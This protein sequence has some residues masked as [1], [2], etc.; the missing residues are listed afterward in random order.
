MRRVIA[1]WI[2]ISISAVVGICC[3]QLVTRSVIV[4]D[5]LGAVCG[6]GHLFALVHGHGIYQADVDRTVNESHYPA[7]AEHTEFQNYWSANMGGVTRIVAHL[8]SSRALG[9]G[10]AYIDGLCNGPGYGLSAIDCIYAYPTATTT[11]DVFPY[12]F[13]LANAQK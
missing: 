8:I 6:R 1:V 9:G 7:G 5:K 10:V 2:S 11:W 12:V 4:R 13:T 3:G